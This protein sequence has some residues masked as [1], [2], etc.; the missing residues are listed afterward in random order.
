MI[1]H[2]L[3]CRDSRSYHP[4]KTLAYDHAGKQGRN[5]HW[6]LYTFRR[7][8][9]SETY[10]LQGNN[11]PLNGPTSKIMMRNW[12]GVAQVEKLLLPLLRR[13]WSKRQIPSFSPGRDVWCLQSRVKT[14][15]PS[16]E[17]QCQNVPLPTPKLHYGEI[18]HL[19]IPKTWE[20]CFYV[21]GS[22]HRSTRNLRNSHC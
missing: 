4:I 9:E 13:R 5:K 18:F 22:V 17:N 2:F 1:K 14:F 20:E 15:L 12:A 6:D 21:T 3:A 7:G 19:A 11:N 10:G 16:F 8:R